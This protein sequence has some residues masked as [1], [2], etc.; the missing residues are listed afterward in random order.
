M[1]VAVIGAA[2]TVGSCITF[3]LITNKLVEEILMIDP[4]EEALKGQWIDI[5][6]VAAAQ[7]ITIRT[8]HYEDMN[9]ADIAIVA[10]GAPVNAKASRL[11]LLAS[12]LPIIK[13]VADNINRYCSKAKVIMET[14]PVDPL[15]YAMYLL[16]LDKDRRRY[17]GYSMNDTLR[18]R[19]WSAEALGVSTTRVNGIVIGEHGNSQV[20]LFSTLRLDGKLVKLDADTENKIREKSPE[21]I[22]T[23]ESLVP[24]RTP[25]WT[26]AY[27][28]AII[29]EAIRNDSKLE[30]PCNAILD[31]EY[32]LR[33][34]STT[35]PVILG[36]EGIESVREIQLTPKEKKE[37][38]SSART[39]RPHMQAVEDFIKSS[40]KPDN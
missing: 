38:E 33:G 6:S 24:K 32:G 14:N 34:I 23:F 16:S 25:G 2:G 7:G 26:S 11:E 37:L 35:V 19:M 36:K 40:Q 3:A 21:I 8:G 4:F 5:S 28:T 29:V 30:V 15:N 20:M 18:F 10:V 39:L 31:G 22:K 9:G 17:I 27:G 1:K 12:S 13:T